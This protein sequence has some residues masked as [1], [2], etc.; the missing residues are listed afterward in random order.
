MNN[1]RLLQ[2]P[3]GKKEFRQIRQDFYLDVFSASAL[4]GKLSIN[5]MESKKLS[6]T[7]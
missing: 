1:N 5:A 6:T 4:N 2:I 3:N 7:S